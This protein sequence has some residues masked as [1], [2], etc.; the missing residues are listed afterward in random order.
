MNKNHVHCFEREFE[1]KVSQST[2]RRMQIIEPYTIEYTYSNATLRTKEVP[3]VEIVMP[4]DQFYNLLE[5]VDE[6]SDENIHW[7]TYKQYQ[8]IY[9]TEWPYRFSD[10]MT[11]EAQE[12]KLRNSNAALKKA[13]EHYQLLLK[14]S[15]D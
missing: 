11:R 6:K 15:H 12:E 1:A 4:K 8:N 9:G 5:K 13:W 2:N 7:L 14:I 3:A 10:M